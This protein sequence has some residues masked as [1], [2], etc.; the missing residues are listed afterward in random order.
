ME[1][2]LYFIYKYYIVIYFQFQGFAAIIDQGNKGLATMHKV[3]VSEA[4]NVFD[5]KVYLSLT[6]TAA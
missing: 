1:L 6:I 5:T 4:N 2:D 3:L